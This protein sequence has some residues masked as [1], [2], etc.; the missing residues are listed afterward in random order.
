M[1]AIATQ[2]PVLES[3]IRSAIKKIAQRNGTRLQ[4]GLKAWKEARV[5]GW[6]NC[7]L[8]LVYGERG[9]LSADAG[10]EGKTPSELM[11]REF[12]L[13]DLEVGSVVTAFDT[14]GEVKDDLRG[15]FALQ[16]LVAH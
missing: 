3:H 9:Q 2:M 4:R 5:R 6:E 13:T 15:Y 1:G 7:P 14:G 10:R 16:A 11:K 8:A 12:G